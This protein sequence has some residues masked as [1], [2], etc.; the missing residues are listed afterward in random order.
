MDA[1]IRLLNVLLPM[2]YA[3]AVAAY[4]TDFARGDAAAVRV[5]RRLMETV[6]AL[7]AVYLGLRTAAFGH[8]P[9]ASTEELLTTVALAVAL[10]YVVVERRSREHRTGLFL[11]GVAFVLQ[12]VSSAFIGDVAEFPAVLRSPLFGLHT[13]SAVVGYAALAVSAAYGVLYLLLYGELKRRRFGRVFDR[14]PPLEALARM[15]LRA[16]RVGLVALGVTI[17]CGSVWAAAEFPRF[18]R[19]PKFLLTVLVWLVY[20]AALALHAARRWTGRR[21]IAVCLVGFVL[22]VAATLLAR[23]A[24]DSF[25]VFA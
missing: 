18:L 5:A 22:L 25:H 9:L 15:S 1:V 12:T 23:F 19:D 11:V 17:A 7:H 13:G 4:A 3:L 16:V 14:L 20:A 2:T 10:V 8:V 24:L 21:T 6:L